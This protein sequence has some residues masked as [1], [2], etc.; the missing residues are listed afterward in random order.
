ML[1][2]E[3]M[4]GIFHTAML[5]LYLNLNNT[6]QCLKYTALELDCANHDLVRFQLTTI[7]IATVYLLE[8]EIVCF[9]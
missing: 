1:L 6:S 8:A 2:S 4:A 9:V 5:N 7:F 3:I